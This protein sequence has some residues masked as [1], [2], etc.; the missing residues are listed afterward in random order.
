MQLPPAGRPAGAVDAVLEY[1][2]SGYALKRQQARKM[3]DSEREF[4]LILNSFTNR[5]RCPAS[6]QV[7]PWTLMLDKV[8]NRWVWIDGFGSIRRSDARPTI[9]P[10]T[11]DVERS[12]PG[13]PVDGDQDGEHARK[14]GLT[15]DQQGGSER[16]SSR[17][18]KLAI[19][20]HDFQKQSCRARYC[21][22]A[23]R[24]QE[25]VTED[26]DEETSW[27]PRLDSFL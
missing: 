12:D 20:Q 26:K 11:P 3:P 18:N 4:H 5:Q 27:N 13:R 10:I 6:T 15:G 9:Q 1:Y 8:W 22:G 16:K 14:Q 21:D 7:L 17:D 24:R 25:P 19:G 2:P 23:C